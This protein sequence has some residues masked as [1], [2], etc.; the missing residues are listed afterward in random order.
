MEKE[1]EIFKDEN[2]ILKCTRVYNTNLCILNEL[3]IKGELEIII[4]IIIRNLE[5]DDETTLC[6]EVYN[7][8]VPDNIIQNNYISFSCEYNELDSYQFDGHLQEEITAT[9]ALSDKYRL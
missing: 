6:I 9:L 8:N 5:D 1:Q 2:G 7:N 4:M 3:I